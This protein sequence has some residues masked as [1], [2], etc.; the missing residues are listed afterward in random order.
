M[1]EIERTRRDVRAVMLAGAMFAPVTA[2]LRSKRGDRAIGEIRGRREAL[3]WREQ[4]RAVHA[5]IEPNAQ[6]HVG[7]GKDAEGMAVIL[8]SLM[9]PSST[10]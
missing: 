4:L 6:A 1:G 5:V 9:S 10:E 3:I 2:P 8:P 7:V